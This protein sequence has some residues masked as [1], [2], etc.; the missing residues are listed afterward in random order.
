[1]AMLTGGCGT[2]YQQQETVNKAQQ[3]SRTSVKAF[4]DSFAYSLAH[5]SSASASVQEMQALLHPGTPGNLRFIL[6]TEVAGRIASVRLAV[7]GEGIG[8]AMLDGE[9]AYVELCVKVSGRHSGSPRVTSTQIRCPDTLPEGAPPAST[10]KG[11]LV[12]PG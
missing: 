3:D 6:G 10:I 9:A 11:V 12:P 2:G 5:R 4:E 1:M 7:F 8:S